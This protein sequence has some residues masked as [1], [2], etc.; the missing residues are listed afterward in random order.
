MRVAIGVCALVWVLGVGD[1]G[2]TPSAWTGSV[3]CTGPN[4]FCHE[5][6]STARLVVSGSTA[7]AVFEG[8]TEAS[9]DPESAR[10]TCT[11]H[12]R[13]VSAKGP[14]RYYHQV[15]RTANGAGG[16]VFNAPCWPDRIGA[17]RTTPAGPRLRA[18]FAHHDPLVRDDPEARLWTPEP[19]Y[20]GYLSRG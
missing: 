9:H 12:Y 20:R 19:L 10:S 1:A 11:L 8:Y 7:T 15:G 4:H 2:A 17:M 18:E 5:R 16:S 6:R 3:G 13:F 14:W